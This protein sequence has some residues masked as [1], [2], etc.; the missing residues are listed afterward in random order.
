MMLPLISDGE[1]CKDVDGTTC[2]YDSRLLGT[3]AVEW[4]SK[5]ALPAI[6]WGHGIMDRRWRDSNQQSEVSRRPQGA[7]IGAH[8]SI[9]EYNQYNRYNIRNVHNEHNVVNVHNHRHQ[10]NVI[11]Y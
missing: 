11:T 1:T 2:D 7:L 4:T 10:T 3:A 5:L 9:I 8:N 6:K